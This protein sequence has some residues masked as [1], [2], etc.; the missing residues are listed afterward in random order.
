MHFR[1][2]MVISSTQG[3]FIYTGYLFTP[4]MPTQ[5]RQKSEYAIYLHSTVFQ[6]RRFYFLQNFIGEKMTKIGKIQPILGLGI[7]P[8]L[9]GKNCQIKSLW[10]DINPVISA[11]STDKR[12]RKDLCM[13]LLPSRP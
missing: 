7:T 3:K 8:I 6:T 2:H 10:P 11:P 13:T 1:G 4:E 12:E 9:G 5:N